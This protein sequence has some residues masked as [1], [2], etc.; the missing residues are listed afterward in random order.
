MTLRSLQRC[1]TSA[2]SHPLGDECGVYILRI[3]GSRC[4]HARLT[5]PKVFAKLAYVPRFRFELDQSQIDPPGQLFRTLIQVA[6][7]TFECS[8]ISRTGIEVNA[9]AVNLGGRNWQLN[10]RGQRWQYVD[11]LDR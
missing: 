3:G 11:G 5:E 10:Q 6:S 4:H 8:A 1:Q 7:M 2:L 9:A